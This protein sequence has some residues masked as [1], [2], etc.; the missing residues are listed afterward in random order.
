MAWDQNE[1]ATVRRQ[2]LLLS[3]P[4]V[5]FAELEAYGAHL[6]STHHGF[7]MF[8]MGFDEAM[9][10]ALLA[11]DNRLIDLGLAR[12]GGN[13]GAVGELYARARAGSGNAEFDKA[14]RMPVL[15][16]D[17][18]INPP[19]GGAELRRILLDGNYEEVHAL[20]RG[21][22]R[23]GLL[24]QAFARAGAFAECTE[25]TWSCAVAGGT[26][27]QALTLA[28][29]DDYAPDFMALDVQDSLLELFFTAPTREPW[30]GILQR[31][32][33]QLDPYRVKH[34]ESLDAAAALLARW[35]PAAQARGK[36]DP[37]TLTALAT[38]E[39]LAVILGALYGRVH[40]G[41]EKTS[42][43]GAAD[44]PQLSLRAAHYGNCRW[45]LDE[46]TQARDRDRDVLLLSALF[47]DSVLLDPKQREFIEN[48]LPDECQWLYRRRCD[49][50]K[51][52]A[53]WFDTRAVSDSLQRHEDTPPEPASAADLRRVTEDLRQVRSELK[54]LSNFVLWGLVVLALV[55]WFTS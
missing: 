12:N 43:L 23:R 50:V 46:L 27:N 47:N 25:E 40:T 33:E 22:R 10:A 42:V 31:L 30:I 1:N 5:V 26:Y 4:D 53:P 24:A 44:S 9:E 35:E 34:P 48:S 49:Q 38:H 3:A 52:H 55:V 37:G 16:N 6:R 36:P 19:G 21:S 8:H 7:T 14:I 13:D 17:S 18:V 2:R 11:R 54:S 51:R 15:S 29:D 32:A 20:M 41:A 39:E 45:T 28:V